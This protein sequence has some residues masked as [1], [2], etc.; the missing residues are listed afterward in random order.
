MVVYERASSHED[1]NATVS[2]PTS[3]QNHDAQLGRYVAELTRIFKTT[4]CKHEAHE[5]SRR[6]LED[7]AADRSFINRVLRHYLLTPGTLNVKNY[8]VV[9]MDV[10]LNPYYHLVANC[11]IP[12]PGHERNISSKAIHHHGHMLLTTL[13]LFGPGYEHWLFTQPEELD[14]AR[15]LYTMDVVERKRHALHN[16]A[17]VDAWKAHLPVYPERLS[18]TLCLWSNQFPTTWKDQI[19]RVPLFKRNEDAL[20]RI[21][22]RI[23]LS[24]SL[25][26]KIVSYF[27]FY[28]TEE[29]FK[30]MR[31]RMEFERG[32]NEDHLHS[33]FHTIQETGNE[34]L[35]VLMKEQLES[36]NTVFANP[37]L[38]R[39]LLHDLQRGRPIEGRLSS[40]HLN[41]PHATFTTETIERALAALRRRTNA[42]AVGSSLQAEAPSTRPSVVAGA[43]HAR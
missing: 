22:Q 36:G 34:A 41:I 3:S 40:C 2:H 33:V 42:G 7:I 6:I 13:T 37:T 21:A 18:I 35:S 27:D 20:R 25:D 9:G 19:K 4:S 39:H 8:P 5:H 43:T 11:W 32:P 16:I 23:G 24:R 29:G 38:I 1:E 10:E 14:G 26:L 28:P 17:F 15:E 31:E 30:G 12:L